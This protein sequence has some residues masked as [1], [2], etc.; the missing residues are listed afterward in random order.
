MKDHPCMPYHLILCL[1]ENATHNTCMIRRPS[2]LQTHST[3]TIKLKSSAG[4]A[5]WCIYEASAVTACKISLHSWYHLRPQVPI[6]HLSA[7]YEPNHLHSS[8]WSECARDLSQIW[9]VI[10]HLLKT[11]WLQES[12]TY[13]QRLGL[14]KSS[15]VGCHSILVL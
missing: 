9:S 10:I 1:K 8:H 4:N 5:V 3:T 13:L 6:L 15:I 12:C 11:K 2:L 7:P 14:S